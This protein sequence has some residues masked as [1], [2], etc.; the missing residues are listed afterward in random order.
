MLR[1]RAMLCLSLRRGLPIRWILT[2]RRYAPPR[3]SDES[4]ILFA[5]QRYEPTFTFTPRERL[6]GM[7]IYAE[8][9]VYICAYYVGGARYRADEL[10]R[11]S[12]EFCARRAII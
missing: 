11:V 8:R 2:P 9:D 4:H 6:P 1:R 5:A 12:R 3:D 10:E 7:R